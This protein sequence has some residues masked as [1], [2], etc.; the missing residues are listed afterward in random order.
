MAVGFF[1]V[2]KFEVGVIIWVCYSCFFK[3]FEVAVP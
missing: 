2:E 3:D 1:C